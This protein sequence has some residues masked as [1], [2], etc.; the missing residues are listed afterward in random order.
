MMR[1]YQLNKIVCLTAFACLLGSCSMTRNIT[2][3]DPLYTGIKKIAYDNKPTDNESEAQHL[4]NMKLEMEAA[5]AAAPNGSLFGS[6]Y[7]R[8][9]WSWRLGV[10]NTFSDKSSGFAKWMTKTFGK[11]PVLMSKVNPALR[12]S[13]AQSVLQ[14]NGYF[15]GEVTYQALPHKNPK[16]SKL[17]YNVHLDTLF[18]YDSIAYVNFPRHIQALI[19][20]TRSESLLKRGAPFTVA[21]LDAERNRLATLLQNNGFYHF[22]PG[23]MSYLADTFATDCKAQIRLQL[24]DGIPPEALRKQYIGNINMQIRHSFMERLTDSVSRRHLHIY[25]SGKRPPVRPAVILKNLRFMPRQAFSHD[26]YVESSANLNSAGVFTTTDFQFLQREGTDTIDL[27]LNCVLDKPYDFYIEGNATGKTSGRYGPQLKLGLTKRNAFRGGEKLDINLNG[28]YE[29]NR[30][31]GAAMNGYQYGADASLEFPRI[32]APFYNS[33]RI[34]RGKDGRLRRRRFLSTPTTTMKVSMSVIRRPEYYSMQI[35][36]G[37]WTYKWQSSETSFHEFSPL[38]MKYQYM[39]D[40]TVEFDSIVTKFP[41]LLTMMDDQFIPKMRYT[42]TYVSPSS[43]P[44]PIRWETTISES[45]NLVSVWDAI[46]GRSFNQKGKTLFKTIYSQ[47]LKLES[48]FTKTWSFGNSKLVGHANA[49]VIVSYGNSDEAPFSE[50]FFAGGANSIRAFGVRYVG[51]GAYDGNAYSRQMRFLLQ[52]GDMKLIGNLEYRT[53]LFGNLHGAAFLDAGNVWFLNPPAFD[54]S[55]Y[56]N[57]EEVRMAREEK[58]RKTFRL[59]SFLNQIALGAGIGLRY[60]LGFLVIRLDWGFALHCP[61]DT[62]KSGYFNVTS[63]KDNQTLHFAIGY[64]F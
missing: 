15:R 62:G 51:P 27:N 13:V 57:P 53:P 14:N 9:P 55:I 26:K 20:S 45:G 44:N 31:G 16:K 6:S 48:D 58:D 8:V 41:Y 32:V 38:I 25:Y 24:A 22:K 7:F 42:Y 35:A 60:D 30:S 64:P 39:N 5:L 19:D 54:E 59:S 49:G 40:W 21:S 4:D 17:A 47:F 11:S 63:F 43:H 46:F 36:S 50:L 12:T 34:R 56:S 33:D 23:Y 52:N 28:N 18:T 10:Y 29:W 61:Y 3:D 1:F 2:E 37:E